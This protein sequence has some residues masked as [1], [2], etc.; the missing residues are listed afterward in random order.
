MEKSLH[1]SSEYLQRLNGCSRWREH[2]AKILFSTLLKKK[3][4]TPT[5]PYKLSSTLCPLQSTLRR[6]HRVSYPYRVTT[7]TQLI[8]SDA[9]DSRPSRELA[10]TLLEEDMSEMSEDMEETCR[11][12]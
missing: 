3:A 5:M 10:G 8:N 4:S 9:E 12:T 1:T 11:G 7:D 2:V 6:A